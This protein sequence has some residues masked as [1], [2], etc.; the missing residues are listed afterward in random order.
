[1]ETKYSPNFLR[2]KRIGKKTLITTDH[3]SWTLLDN[4]QLSMLK[5]NESEKD[6]KLFANLEKKG[7][8][9]T[10]KNKNKIVE[11]YRKKYNFLFNGTSLHIVVP[12]LRCDHKCVYC[13]SEAKGIY[14][15]GYDMSEETARKIVEFIAQSPSDIIKIEFQGG[16][17]LLRFD[18][19]QYI[20]E[21]AKRKITKKRKLNFSLVTNLSRMDDDILKYLIKN[22]VGL[23]TSFDGPKN[24]H[25]KNRLFLSGSSYDKVTYWIDRIKRDYNYEI[26]ALMVTTRYSLQFWKEIVD[27]YEKH[28]M[29]WIKFR[30]ADK[31]GFAKGAWDKISYSAE[32]YLKFWRNAVDYIIKS[33]KKVAERGIA[34]IMKK[35][36]GE[37]MNLTDSESPCG[38]A[39]AQIAYDQHGNIFTCDEGRMFDIFKLGNV[40][41]N[42]YRELL[43]SGKVCSMIAA[44]TNDTLICDS[45]V[46]K[47]FCSVCPVCNYS[48]RGNI[49]PFIP[50]SDRCKIN[51]GI[52]EYI[53][54]KIDSSKK[55]EKA[56]TSWRDRIEKEL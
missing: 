3:G 37:W 33:K 1:M 35:L 30:Q 16:E 27:E 18:I 4:R 9:V 43:T 36:N 22:C 52:F 42:T 56:F 45:C 32:E 7:I 8:I 15:K 25:D 24:V 31:I 39:I 23:C 6:K 53:I 40:F 26:G 34:Y 21:E 48:E 47:P 49:I 38:A 20:I 55:Y 29:K 50:E 14:E 10:E 13:H 5:R 44:S 19:V 54:E 17:P 2:E 46:W 11:S 12:T 41:D 51:K 28:Q